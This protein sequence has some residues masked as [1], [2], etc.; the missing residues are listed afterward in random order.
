MLTEINKILEVTKVI[1]I[2]DIHGKPLK[3]I[4]RCLKIL[5]YSI[6]DIDGVFG[7]RTRTAFEEFSGGDILTHEIA[8]SLKERMEKLVPITTDIRNKDDV[9]RDILQLANAYGLVLPQQKAYIIA[10]VEH[11]TA[12]TFQPVREL[13]WKSEDFR[14]RLPYY[15]YYGRGYVQLTHRRNYQEYS[16]ILNIDMV[17]NPD[18]ALQHD[19]AVF[20]LVHGFYTGIFTGY[21]LQKFINPNLCNYF[22]ARKCINGLDKASYIARLA[23][24]YEEKIKTWRYK[25]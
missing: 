23:E 24:E 19:I 1:E 9:I 7:A 16:D 21:K 15:P 20:V 8:D 14:K 5:G 11:E 10:T 18:I 12:K 3:E 22:D 2:K 6:G 17:K 25:S 4:Q 13:F